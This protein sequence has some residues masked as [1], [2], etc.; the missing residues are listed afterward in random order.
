MFKG[1]K[2]V[3]QGNAVI[4][5]KSL[6][7]WP[8]DLPPA[9]CPGCNKLAPISTQI[10]R[11]TLYSTGNRD[12]E[13]RNLI[14]VPLSLGQGI[15]LYFMATHLTTLNEEKRDDKRTPT[16]RASGVR[17]AQVGEILRIVD[18]LRTAEQ[19]K[20]P[21]TPI[22]LAGDFNA[23]PGS[24]ELD[25]LEQTFVRPNPRW[26]DGSDYQGEVWIHL[27]HRIHVDHVFYDDPN[28]LLSPIDCFVLGLSQVEEVTDHFPVVAK[29]KI[30]R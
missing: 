14:V 17:L 9:G 21:K 24:P 29:F 13:P 7:Q 1:F 10:S 28:G 22:I 20:E 18:E 27:K 11:A 6:A 3:K 30:K 2:R 15:S 25:A 4:T 8:W 19:N 16:Q 26:C 23:R 12:T 5:N